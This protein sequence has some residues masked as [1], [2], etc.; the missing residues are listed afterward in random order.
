MSGWPAH[1]LLY[2]INTW[3]WLGE[4][5]AAAG[6]PITLADVP[7]S[8]LERIGA[9]GFDGVWLMGVWERSPE[10]RD[11]ASSLTDLLA[12]Y[13]RALPDFTAADVVGSPYAIHRYEVDATLGGGEALAALRDRLRQLGLRL[14]LDFVPN[15]FAI[16]HPWLVE[17]PNRFVPAT[18]DRHAT[19]PQNY[20]TREIDG[21]S[22]TFAHGR[23]PNYNGWTDT[24]QLDYR[25][26]DTRRALC[27][28]LAGIADQ[29]D[30][31]RCDMAM[32]VIR[33]VF[34][35]TWGGEFDP[36]DADFWSEAIGA[37]KVK[38]P[39]FVF[40]GEVYWDLEYRLQQLGFDY[41]YDKRLYDRLVDGDAQ[42]VRD[43]LRASFE[44]QRRLVR[45]IE[46]HDEPRAVTTFGPERNRAA[47][48]L[49]LTLP[50]MRLVHEGQ[51]E[52]RHVKI[53]VQLGR[54]PAEPADL[55]MQ[56]YYERLLQALSDPL[57]HEGAWQLL[58]PRP[59]GI[60]ES[61][62]GF[63]AH[64]WSSGDARRLVIVNWSPNQAQCLLPLDVPALAG[65][66]WQL[67]DLL[68]AAEYQR[69]GEDLLNPGLYLDMPPYSYHL[70]EFQRPSLP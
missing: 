7:Q 47:A 3:P 64:H 59:A 38:H 12:E 69:H 60:G 56:A 5:S 18:A 26:R 4:M 53:P 15:H 1:P 55:L 20:F 58:D 67:R 8:E 13:Q 25:T 35:R 16:D 46:N 2:E 57:S 54:R 33:D 28:L 19:A 37:V 62:R 32:L 9:L 17:Y 40:V 23:D 29:C 10:A 52:G 30:G 66:L 45:F 49:A 34:V 65:T 63:I 6:K 68:G 27:E 41:T 22:R 31:V 21:T 51:I 44:F 61:H 14:I 42:S 39:A 50:G 43:H 24:V 48:V 36:P 11:I 70:F